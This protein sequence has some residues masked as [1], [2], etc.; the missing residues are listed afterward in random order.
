[1]F[2]YLANRIIFEKLINNNKLLI[3]QHVFLNYFCSNVFG[4]ALTP[5]RFPK[6]LVL[7]QRIRGPNL[8]IRP[9]RKQALRLTVTNSIININKLYL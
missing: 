1:M 6:L 9:L 4:T 3:M 8:E 5:K 7:F 2:V